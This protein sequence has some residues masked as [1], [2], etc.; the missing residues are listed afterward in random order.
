[1]TDFQK[2]WASRR[3]KW[4][5]QEQVRIG[6]IHDE[7]VKRGCD[8]RFLEMFDTRIWMY[9]IQQTKVFLERHDNVRLSQWKVYLDVILEKRPHH[10]KADEWK[11]SIMMIDESD[12]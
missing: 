10:E 3:K 5:H 7:C 8:V 4:E 9:P 11:K 12:K 6:D 2:T 1:M